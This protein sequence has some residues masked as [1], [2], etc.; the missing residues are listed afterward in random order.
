MTTVMAIARR[1]HCT[2]AGVDCTAATF[3]AHATPT[4]GSVN[5]ALA[6]TW[7]G[8]GI[9]RTATTFALATLLFVAGD[10]QAVTFNDGLTHIIDAANSFPFEDVIVLDGPGPST[11]TIEIVAGGEFGTGIGDGDLQVF[12][13][14]AVIMSGGEIAR[15]LGVQGAAHAILSGGLSGGRMQPEAPLTPETTGS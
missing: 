5:L 8:Y 3:F 12:D 1:P 11:T 4:R 14:T 10:A 9:I 2:R 15:T 6:L 7:E 13:S